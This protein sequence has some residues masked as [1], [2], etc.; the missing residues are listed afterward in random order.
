VAP[1]KRWSQ[2][3]WN[4]KQISIRA[5]EGSPVARGTRIRLSAMVV[6]VL[7]AVVSLRM[8]EGPPEST[9]PPVPA[10]GD[11]RDAPMTHV[12]D[13]GR[14]T[15]LANCVVISGTLTASRL[16]SAFL[17][18]KAAVTVD[19]EYQKFL[20]PQNSGR[21]IVDV[22]PTDIPT[23]ELPARGTHADF[24]GAWVLNR[25]T[26][27]VELH[28]TWKV[29]LSRA[30]KQL[31]RGSSERDPADLHVGQT[32]KLDLRLPESVT[33]GAPISVDVDARWQTKQGTSQPASQARMFLEM[34]DAD[35]T[36][37]RW[38]A[39]RTNTLGRASADLLTLQVPGTYQATLYP[40]TPGTKGPVTATITVKRG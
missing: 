25:A 16:E 38:K 2:L 36:G 23:V 9:V 21:L 15:V 33:V 7:V 32:L 8:W 29:V 27:A 10:A 39:L 34:T 17:D 26:K 28:P 4:P 3:G 12:H 11:C 1:I 18:Q 37:V 14:F 31:I 19:R 30:D 35:G 24:Y 22:I 13:P 40:I 5:R 6:A 20:P